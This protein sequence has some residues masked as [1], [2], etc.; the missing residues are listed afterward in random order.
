MTHPL[1]GERPAL[2]VVAWPEAV[3]KGQT[4]REPASSIQRTVRPRRS[5]LWRLFV[6]NAAVLLV[7]AALLVLTPVTISAPVTL[8]E[9]ALI[10]GAVIAMLAAT[11]LLLRRALSPL[12]ELTELM[13]TIDPLEPGRRLTGASDADA[14]VATLVEAFNAMLDRLEQE[15][16]DSARRALAAQEEERL[17]IARD[18]HDGIGQRL[19]A[20]AMQAER[21]AHDP[22]G[23]GQAALLEIPDAIREGID[24]VRR[25]SRELRPE[26]LDDLGLANALL[27]LCRRVARHSGVRVQPELDLAGGIPDLSSE[28]ELVIYRVAQE[29]LTNAIRHA[30]ATQITVALRAAED[31]IALRVRDDGRGIALPLPEDTSGISGMRERALLIGAQLNIHSEPGAGTEVQLDA[32]LDG[33]PT[34]PSR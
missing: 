6:A 19:T 7:A 30:E 27:T 22:Q 11:L 16:R 20:V 18:L 5:L 21:V 15:R 10:V 8:G 14:E 9:L 31:H 24:A 3:A 13:R 29:A 26:A 2:A 32:P 1:N 4:V 33:A 12:E 17:R 25:I 28:T 34:C 23:A